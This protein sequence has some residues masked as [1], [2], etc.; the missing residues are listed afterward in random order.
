MRMT[1]KFGLVFGTGEYWRFININHCFNELGPKTCRALL[2]MYSFTGCDSTSSFYGRSKSQWF[3]K[4]MSYPK[5]EAIINIFIELSWAPSLENID[6][7]VTE[8]EKFVNFSYGMDPDIPSVNEARYQIFT[9]S[10]SDN[11]IQLPPSR[12]S[13]KLHTLRSA[14]QAGWVWRNSLQ[15]I[16]CLP[17]TDWGWLFSQKAVH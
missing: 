6:E 9:Q 16:T 15:Q 17:L 8:I 5:Q 10:A 12:M 1:F 14:F 13:P 4:L 2:F 3:K 11:L 7:N